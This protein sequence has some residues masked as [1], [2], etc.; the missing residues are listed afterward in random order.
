MSLHTAG[1]AEEITGF[2]SFPLSIRILVALLT[3][4]AP[5]DT[6]NASSKPIDFKCSQHIIHIV[7]IIKLAVQRWRRQRDTV[8]II[9]YFIEGIALRIFRVVRAD[10]DAFAAIDAA[11]GNKCAPSHYAHGLL[12]WGTA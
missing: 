12:R 5:R 6:S 10:S 7:Q 1:Q 9:Q 3:S 2:F 8:F 4:S 11:L